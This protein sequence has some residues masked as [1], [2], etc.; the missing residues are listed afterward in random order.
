MSDLTANFFPMQWRSFR[1]NSRWGQRV[2]V[3]AA[4]VTTVV[5]L[6]LFPEKLH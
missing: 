1:I 4:T 6:L 3:A 5:L 2:Y